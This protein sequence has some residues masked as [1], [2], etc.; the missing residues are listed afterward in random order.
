MK[1]Q[2]KPTIGP[3][4]FIDRVIKRDEKGQPFSLAP[5]QHGVLEMA[6]RRTHRLQCRLVSDKRRRFVKVVLSSR[7]LARACPR[8][9]GYGITIREPGRNVPVQAVN[10]RCADVVI[11]WRGS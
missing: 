3:L 9:N 7:Y 1:R 10:G 8:C 4:E 2:S 6:L 11:T 5:Y